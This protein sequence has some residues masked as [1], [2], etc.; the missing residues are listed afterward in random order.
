MG[1]KYKKTIIAKIY[2]SKEA[3][4][5]GERSKWSRAEIKILGK[6]L[7]KARSV[8]K[9]LFLMIEHSKNFA[10]ETV[11]SV[12]KIWFNDQDNWMWGEIGV[13]DGCVAEDITKG[14]MTGISLCYRINKDDE[15]DKMPVEI[16]LTDDPDFP[17]ARII[18]SHNSSNNSNSNKQLIFPLKKGAIINSIKSQKILFSHS[19][20]M[21]NNNNNNNSQAQQQNES[22]SMNQQPAGFPLPG[23]NQQQGIQ[24]N[25]QQ[26]TQQAPVGNMFNTNAS[27]SV[28]TA[29]M[30][31]IPGVY[32]ASNGGYIVVNSESL[33]LARREALK[34]GIDSMNVVPRS[35]KTLGVD[36]IAI[37][38]D[39]S[40]EGQA[41]FFQAMLAG[42]EAALTEAH[43]QARQYEAMKNKFEQEKLSRVN[44]AREE[45]VKSLNPLS[46]RIVGQL[47]SGKTIS[48]AHLAKA[49]QELS[50]RLANPQ[51]K[52][53]VDINKGYT[54]KID[55]SNKKIEQL[56]KRNTQ[57]MQYFQQQ[58]AIKESG[59]KV[60]SPNPFVNQSQDFRDQN[61]NF[62]ILSH[63]KMNQQ[64]QQQPKE[65][66]SLFDQFFNE[67]IT[68]PLSNNMF[69]DNTTTG[70]T[71]SSS[72]SSSSNYEVNEHSRGTKR[73]RTSSIYL[74][75]YN[76]Q[77]LNKKQKIPSGTDGKY[78]IMAHSKTAH[79]LSK[80]IQKKDNSHFLNLDNKRKLMEN[81]IVAIGLRNQ[82]G[83]GP[84]NMFKEN[85]ITKW[86]EAFEYLIDSAYV[87]PTAI[88]TNASAGI[89]GC[90]SIKEN[91]NLVDSNNC[92]HR[93]AV[94][95][96]YGVLASQFGNRRI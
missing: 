93:P 67:S 18:V 26:G 70:L 54:N 36:E 40:P 73:G 89:F 71:S 11:G 28:K 38:K 15:S 49:S 27:E 14:G 39:L 1:K 47:S 63:S 87:T 59:L 75:A 50:A 92:M 56:E 16:S 74:D 65:D 21:Q 23:G 68:K 94:M 62:S 46:E 85:M 57:M 58:Q 35:I 78:L 2:P 96:K 88:Q 12:K 9:K 34:L 55:E 17:K 42:K 32:K 13:T 66:V 8:G 69:N 60:N 6:V 77:V 72:S 51:N 95:A 19:A 83:E 81:N 45:K 76:T 82:N 7:K 64:Q 53:M 37:H 44:L 79:A 48:D 41:R 33:G 31:K 61:G 5:G 86:P 4:D 91:S 22:A 20:T 43:T 24:Q 84:Y 25:T 10:E 3:K 52:W 30:E 90:K 29:T 80:Q